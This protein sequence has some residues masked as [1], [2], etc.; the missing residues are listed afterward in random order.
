[1]AADLSYVEACAKNIARVALHTDKIMSLKNQHLPVRTAEKI[2]E[3]LDQ[4]R[5]MDV[6]F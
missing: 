6:T 4:Q 2:K 3:I 1:M 5:E